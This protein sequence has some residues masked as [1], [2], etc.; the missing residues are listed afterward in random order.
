MHTVFHTVQYTADWYFIR[1]QVMCEV[2]LWKMW[3]NYKKRVHYF[4][5]T[6]FVSFALLA[7]VIEIM[8]LLI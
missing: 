8:H 1:V 5:R 3:V 2:P 4:F 6:K 7:I